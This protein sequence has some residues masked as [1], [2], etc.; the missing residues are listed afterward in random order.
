MNSR[1]IYAL[2]ICLCCFV[3]YGQ[4]NNSDK[5]MG[6]TDGFETT[7]SSV[8]SD[9]PSSDTLT[10]GDCIDAAI[11]AFKQT[12]I[13]TFQ[14][15]W[16]IAHG[17]MAFGK[18]YQIIDDKSDKPISAI[19]F[20]L[21]Q[22]QRKGALTYLQRTSSGVDVE[23]G[24]SARKGVQDH[25][26]Q[27]LYI[28]LESGANPK[29]DI[30]FDSEKSNIQSILYKSLCD[31]NLYQDHSY[32]LPAYVLAW[33]QGIVKEEILARIKQIVDY[34]DR[35]KFQSAYCASGIHSMMAISYF[36]N[37]CETTDLGL[38][39]EGRLLED[40]NSD[41]GKYVAGLRKSQDEFGFVWGPGGG[42]ENVAVAPPYDNFFG[43]KIVPS[44]HI[45]EFLSTYKHGEMV[46][47]AWVQH[48]AVSVA[49]E[50]LVQ[51]FRSKDQVFFGALC[52]AYRGLLAFKKASESKGTWNRMKQM[53]LKQLGKTSGMRI[54]WGK[55]DYPYSQSVHAHLD[56]PETSYPQHQ[57]VKGPQLVVF[58]PLAYDLGRI[59]GTK[60]T[61]FDG[62]R[63][64]NAS[65]RDI[66]V[67]ETKASCGCM[68]TKITPQRIKSKG[69][70]VI[71]GD[72]LAGETSGPVD[73]TI[74]LVTDCKEQPLVTY[75]VSGYVES[76]LQVYPRDI[77]YEVVLGDQGKEFYDV[78][79]LLIRGGKEVAVMP[80]SQFT[81]SC[82]N[83]SD[84]STLLNV[85]INH[86]AVEENPSGSLQLM[87][88]NSKNGNV[89]VKI[90]ITGKIWR[91]LKPSPDRLF[92]GKMK[93]GERKNA[94]V[95][96]SNI[97]RGVKLDR[98]VSTDRNGLAI[99]GE[100]DSNAKLV[101]IDVLAK[102]TGLR[103]STVSIL[104]QTSG[105]NMTYELPISV[106][107]EK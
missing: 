48:L 9:L 81:V 88:K 37:E 90:P 32:T 38:N 31:F 68:N 97:G 49:N 30:L 22:R 106:V 20:L 13:T 93:I 4:E 96:I 52:H 89:G 67:K 69:F 82:R 86:D 25:Q 44:G 85:S 60:R 42:P 14:S 3:C 12:K 62:I 95:S 72:V 39:F 27:F 94:S 107:V 77:E 10:V 51:S 58:S 23:L 64:I 1:Y 7:A 66:V 15:P 87:I 75:K 2:L 8:T 101:N 43:P 53:K 104:Y 47:E 35:T 29:T 5:W 71:S 55:G 91:G 17:L 103:T 70:A 105:K 46:N 19:D 74:A 73:Y 76:N 28:L 33:Q 11:S 50:L 56:D 63:V 78:G 34:F 59:E 18:D 98:V 80:G 61:H 102:S 41:L 26:D 16:N 65:D 92:V 79:S 57:S 36:L 45:L 21:D 84:A 6:N 99:A 24:E 83:L 54:C 100:I 40:L